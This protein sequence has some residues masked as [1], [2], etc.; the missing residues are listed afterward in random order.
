MSKKSWIPAYAGMTRMESPGV[1]RVVWNS[2]E[3]VSGIYFVRMM[4]DGKD[5]KQKVVLLK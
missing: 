2:G 5:Y 3:C 4:A 1:H